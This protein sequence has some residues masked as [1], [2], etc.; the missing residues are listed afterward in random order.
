MFLNVKILL[1][2]GTTNGQEL[3]WKE[4]V[5]SDIT[6]VLYQ[7]GQALMI[8]LHLC[9]TLSLVEKLAYGSR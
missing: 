1:D 7:N 6:L 3:A 2:T 4:A 8:L 5:S 9:M